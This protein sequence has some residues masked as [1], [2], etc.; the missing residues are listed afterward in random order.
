MAQLVDQQGLRD[1]EYPIRTTVGTILDLV[2]RDKT[3]IYVKTTTAN[4]NRNP[5]YDNTKENITGYW[6]NIS[7]FIVIFAVLSVIFLEFI[8]KDKR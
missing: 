6:I 4:A 1:E 3:E 8:D 5:I 2:G 7:S